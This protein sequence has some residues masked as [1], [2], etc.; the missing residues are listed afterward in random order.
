MTCLI[1]IDQ[2]PGEFNWCLAGLQA[3][4]F[5]P[6]FES[7]NSL[8]QIVLQ[9]L[10]VI[11]LAKPIWSFLG[12]LNLDLS[13][14]RKWLR[15]HEPSLDVGWHHEPLSRPVRGDNYKGCK[16]AYRFFLSF[17]LNSVFGTCRISTTSN[18]VILFPMSAF[19]HVKNSPLNQ[20]RWQ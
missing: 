15:T 2:K 1:R 17:F 16:F 4:N 8:S 7:L 20:L 12:S 14:E 3:S 5:W 18:M 10:C 6:S 13:A 9:I 11:K 19:A